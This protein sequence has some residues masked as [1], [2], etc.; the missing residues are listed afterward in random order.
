MAVAELPC[1]AHTCAIKYW[2]YQ[3]HSRINLIFFLNFED[4]TLRI[5]ITIQLE[6]HVA[7]W[8]QVFWGK[9][10]YVCYKIYC[11]TNIYSLTVTRYPFVITRV[12]ENWRFWNLVCVNNPITFI[13]S[14]R[15]HKTSISGECT[16]WSKQKRENVHPWLFKPIIQTSKIVFFGI[17]WCFHIGHS[18]RKDIAPVG[19]IVKIAPK[20]VVLKVA[21]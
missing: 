2:V 9:Q 14:N 15:S 21:I 12:E 18:I 19:T 17:P 10:I 8:C 5:S 13:T 11:K 1:Q 16:Y 6:L 7:S 20:I 3:L 4:Y